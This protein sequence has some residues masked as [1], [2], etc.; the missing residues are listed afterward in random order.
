MT[1]EMS[2]GRIPLVR[3]RSLREQVTER[4]RTD[5]LSGNFAQKHLPSVRNLAGRFNCSTIVISGALDV[6]QNEG[7]VI[8]RAGKGV[9]IAEGV[10]DQAAQMPATR[11]GN[12]ALFS[13]I[14]QAA[15]MEDTYY[16]EVW[17]GMLQAAASSD[18]RLTAVHLSGEKAGDIVL[19]TAEDI[20]LEGCIVLGIADARIV[21]EVIEV[22]LPTVVADHSFDDD[23]NDIDFEVDCVDLDSESGSLDAVRHLIELGHRHI[24]FM[25]NVHPD[26]NPGR[27]RGYLRA[28]KEAG[29]Q[30]EEGFQLRG[31]PSLDGGYKLMRRTLQAGSQLPT[32]FLCWGSTMLVGARRALAERGLDVPGNLSMVGCGSRWFSNIYPD[33][34]IAAADAHLLGVE[35][36]RKLLERVA[37]PHGRISTKQIPMELVVRTSTAPPCDNDMAGSKKEAVKS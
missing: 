18:R 24:G 30:V 28:M 1:T 8:R 2:V 3:R 25:G 14:G 33:V 26:Y 4:L 34:T 13:R 37:D 31:V 23:D 11:T 6:L 10:A 21:R 9:F 20:P 22:G 7:L 27:Q 19:R 15:I 16:A 12:I 32:A 17:A 5:I 35:A 36:V 29:L